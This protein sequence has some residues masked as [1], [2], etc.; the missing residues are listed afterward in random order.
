M[1]RGRDKNTHEKDAQS[2]V[3]LLK[4][5]NNPQLYFFLA[6]FF[7]LWGFSNPWIVRLYFLGRIENYSVQEVTY[8]NNPSGQVSSQLPDQTNTQDIPY[9]THKELGPIGDWLGGTSTPLLTIAGFLMILASFIL[10]RQQL[11]SSQKEVH[12]Q[13]YTLGRQRFD[14]TFFNMV[15]LHNEIVK[16]MEYTE[17]KYNPITYTDFNRKIPVHI[18]F[19]VFSKLIKSSLIGRLRGDD[20][21]TH[22]F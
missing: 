1:R 22:K 18:S 7:A 6:I 20:D 8:S 5:V 15:Q 11:L 9:P 14:S 19:F 10:Q 17:L 16:S 13:K 2:G 3:N 21:S 12:E 4:L